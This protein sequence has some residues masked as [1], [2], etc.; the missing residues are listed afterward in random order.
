MAGSIAEAGSL[1]ERESISI[2][3]AYDNDNSSQEQ[4]PR[5]CVAF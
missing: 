5:Y 3:P 1:C 4:V 2:M